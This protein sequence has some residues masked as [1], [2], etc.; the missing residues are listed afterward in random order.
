MN[1][2]VNRMGLAVASAMAIFY[3]AGYLSLAGFIA[4]KLHP[5][6]HWLQLGQAAVSNV[7][8]VMKDLLVGSLVFGVWGYLF[9]AMVAWVYNRLDQ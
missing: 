4:L 8:F 3:V 2:D 6:W 1:F 5:M 9:G 7:T